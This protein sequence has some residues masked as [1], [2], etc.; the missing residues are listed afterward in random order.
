[1]LSTVKKFCLNYVYHFFQFQHTCYLN[2][3][4]EH[5]GSKMWFIDFAH[6]DPKMIQCFQT[7]IPHLHSHIICK[8]SLSSYFIETRVLELINSSGHFLWNCVIKV[9]PIG[10]HE[11]L[12]SKE[13]CSVTFYSNEFVQKYI[14][15]YMKSFSSFR[16]LMCKFC[17]SQGFVMFFDEFKSFVAFPRGN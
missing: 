13:S 11:S 3:F 9:K 17:V 12:S 5:P 8:W 4:L 16:S 14:S 7:T 1:M 6:F 2:Y 10:V 15:I